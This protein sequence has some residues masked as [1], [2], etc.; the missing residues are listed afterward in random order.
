LI[1][2]PAIRS[3]VYR[4]FVDAVTA[5]LQAIKVGDG[6]Q[7]DSQMG[8]LANERRVH[9]MEAL[10]TDAANKGAKVA[11]GGH[12]IGDDGFYFSPTVLDEVPPDVRFMNDE[13]F[14]P[15]APMRRLTR[16]DDAIRDANRL[17]TSL[18]S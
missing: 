12:R 1:A 2:H 5:T 18:V 14:G 10:V 11:F 13:P 4:K 3:S 9:A 16:L 17:R 15:V 8:P 6:R 7:P